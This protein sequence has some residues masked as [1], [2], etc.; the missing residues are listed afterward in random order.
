MMK[1]NQLVFIRNLVKDKDM[2]DCNPINTFIKAGN[3]I[4]IQKEND[5]KEDDCKIYQ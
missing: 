2:Q 1:I 5:Y 4:K 3:F